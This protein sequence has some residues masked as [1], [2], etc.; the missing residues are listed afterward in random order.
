MGGQRIRKLSAKMTPQ[1]KKN[2]FFGFFFFSCTSTHR[3]TTFLFLSK[4]HIFSRS[5]KLWGGKEKS[6]TLNNE[7]SN[8]DDERRRRT[9]WTIIIPRQDSQNSRANKNQD[10]SWDKE[11]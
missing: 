8:D 10:R 11:I 5:E 4:F 9:T 3:G 1:A 7:R 2:T 6:V